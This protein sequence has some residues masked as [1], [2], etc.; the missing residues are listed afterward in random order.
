MGS[1]FIIAATDMEFA[2]DQLE[3]AGWGPGNFSV[4]LVPN[5]ERLA[6]HAA[7]HV[8]GPPAFLDDIRRLQIEMTERAD[9]DRVRFADMLAE[10]LFER[11]D[12]EKD[13]VK[14]N[15]RMTHEGK[16]LV[17]FEGNPFAPPVGWREQGLVARMLAVFR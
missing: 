9:D 15:E 1:S 7:C 11:H 3:K 16:Q 5:G 8:W 2:N 17:T 14:P 6:K 4:P 13:P 12:P 10:G